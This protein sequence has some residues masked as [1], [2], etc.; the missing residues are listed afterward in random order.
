[1][2]AVEGIPCTIDEP[3]L[4]QALRFVLSLIRLRAPRDWH[5]L[6]RRVRVIEWLPT[7]DLEE[8]GHLGA[9]S[10]D[11]WGDDPFGYYTTTGVVQL[12]QKIPAHFVGDQAVR[13]IIGMIAHEL[14]HAVTR[15]RDVSAHA[16]LY[17]ERRLEGV[18]G[19]KRWI[20]ELCAS[21]YAVRWGFETETRAMAA[22][23]LDVILPGHVLWL[24][25]PAR[26]AYRVN[27]RF[28][29]HRCPRRDRVS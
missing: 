29:L 19:D 12:P 4:C 15:P 24:G 2:M 1:M 5:R 20:L 21:M 23:G 10:V 7:A 26:T 8:G 28:F 25:R 14:G 22:V 17:H 27:H 3:A 9:W 16:S 6:R 13:G 18:Y 11:P